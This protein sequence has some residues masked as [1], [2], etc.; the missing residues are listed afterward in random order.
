MPRLRWR[1]AGWRY[2]RRRLGYIIVSLVLVRTVTEG[3]LTFALLAL[4]RLGRLDSLGFGRS[5]AGGSSI[6]FGFAA[7]TE[8]VPDDSELVSGV[9]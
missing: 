9:L 4:A 1:R 7:S 8:L 6:A 2:H 5:L 3:H